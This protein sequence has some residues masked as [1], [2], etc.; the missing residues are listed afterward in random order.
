VFATTKIQN[1]LKRNKKNPPSPF[2]IH[3]PIVIISSHPIPIPLIIVIIVI[4]V[5]VPSLSCLLTSC[6]LPISRS[7]SLHPLRC[8]FPVPPPPP[9]SLSPLTSCY[10][11]PPSSL[12]ALMCLLPAFPSFIP[13]AL[14]SLFLFP[15]LSLCPSHPCS[16][17]KIDLHFPPHPFTP[18]ILFPIPFCYPFSVVPA[19]PHIPSITSLTSLSF[20]MRRGIHTPPHRGWVLDSGCAH[21]RSARHHITSCFSPPPRSACLVTRC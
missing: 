6:W 4:V 18:C 17:S 14:T 15:S 20:P 11:F 2:P 1:L 12:R 5:I 9:L 16:L 8:V 19:F 13:V 10:P 3:I 21:L 7:A